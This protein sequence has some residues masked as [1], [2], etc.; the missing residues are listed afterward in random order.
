MI[1]Y[2]LMLL[3][4]VMFCFVAACSWVVGF[5]QDVT[6]YWDKRNDD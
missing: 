2:L 5:I 3:F 4:F 6:R 1:S